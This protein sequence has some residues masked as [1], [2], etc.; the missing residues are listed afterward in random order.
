[1]KRYQYRLKEASGLVAAQVDAPT[2]LEAR[3]EIDHYAL[4]YGQDG[5]VTV[6]RKQGRAWKLV[7][8]LMAEFKNEQDENPDPA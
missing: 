2:D 5:I 7:Y 3:R 1:M 8:Q 4:M 6:E